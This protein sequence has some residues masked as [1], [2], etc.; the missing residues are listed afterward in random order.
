MLK[1]FNGNRLQP[2][3]IHNVT[4]LS[5]VMYGGGKGQDFFL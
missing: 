1:Q 2:C 3:S 4:L 5:L